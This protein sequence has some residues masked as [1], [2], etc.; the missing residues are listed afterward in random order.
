[1]PINPII[2]VP[3][4]R[5]VPTDLETISLRQCSRCFSNK[6]LALIAPEGL[7]LAAYQKLIPN[8]QEVRV[9]PQCMASVR[10][11][12]RMMI[13]SKIYEL[14]SHHSHMLVH[15]PDAIVLRDELEFWCEQPY[16]YIGAPWFVGYQSPKPD[17]PILG[18]GNFGFSLH[19]PSTMLEILRQRQ[20]WYGRT[21]LRSD[22]SRVRRA[23]EASRLIR[24]LRGIGQGGTL[25]GAWTIYEENCDVFWS[26]LVPK[27]IKDFRIAPPEVALKFSWEVAPS[28]CYAL[29]NGHLPFGLHAWARYDLDFVKLLLARRGVQL[30]QS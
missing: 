9:E 16:D 11:Y 12:N 22:L 14:L 8:A 20:R 4:H 25:R 5:P 6:T 2:V 7:D 10:S 30:N 29:C 1:L 26:Q 21:E 3:V 17:A 19:R 24:V 18:V 27:F 13:N 15:E 28:R 23:G